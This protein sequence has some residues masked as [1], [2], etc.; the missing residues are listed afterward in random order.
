[1]GPNDWA[2][3]QGRILRIPYASSKVALLH[4]VTYAMSI[5][6]RAN[7][8]FLGAVPHSHDPSVPHLPE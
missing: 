3:A 6:R 7:D 1:M 5:E 4:I 2:A 8:M